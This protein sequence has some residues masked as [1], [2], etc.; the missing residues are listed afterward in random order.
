MVKDGG[1]SDNDSTPSVGLPCA[2]KVLGFFLNILQ[3]HAADA[4][5]SASLAP[6]KP[7]RQPS[8]AHGSPRY[9]HTLGDTALDADTL[10]LVLSLKTIHAM[11][12]VD[13]D[14][15]NTRNLFLRWVP[16]LITYSLLPSFSFLFLFIEILLTYPSF[17]FQ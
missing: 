2:L 11:L 6:V 8:G 1:G 16:I 15:N 17:S 4:A 14:T 5:Q 10:E 7:T 9:S 3:K 13:G 12:L